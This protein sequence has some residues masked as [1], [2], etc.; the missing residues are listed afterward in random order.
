MAT[1]PTVELSP[2]RPL[3]VHIVMPAWRLYERAMRSI[4]RLAALALLASIIFATLSPIEMRPH[5][6][7]ANM[8]R[9]LAYVLLGLALALGYPARLMQTMLFVCAVAGVLELLQ[10]IDPGRHARLHDAL[11]KAVAG[12]V[13]IAIGRMV[14][15]VAGRLARQQ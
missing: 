14:L 13:G 3:D 10:A 4:S 6:G 15:A 11:L 9:A 5:M 8:E 1:L 7:G 2:A 12:L